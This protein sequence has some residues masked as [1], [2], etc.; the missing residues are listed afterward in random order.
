MKL[1][2]ATVEKTLD[3]FDAQ[4]IPDSHPAIP[5]LNKRFG[6]HTFF[7]DGDGLN[8]V[9]PTE[10]TAAGAPAGRV[11]RLASWGDEDRTNLVLHSPEET[12][13]IVELGPEEA[14]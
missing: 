6:D 13:I 12:S 1:A 11:V 3:Q 9:E 4:A 2:S 7:L 10:P 5:D 14:A 8:I